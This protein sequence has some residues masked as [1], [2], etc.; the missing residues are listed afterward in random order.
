MSTPLQARVVPFMAFLL[1]GLLQT[2]PGETMRYWGYLAKTVFGAILL[3]R[4]WPLVPEARWKWSWEAVAA[5]VLVLV[6]WVG[7]E[8][9]YPKLGKAGPAWNPFAT[10][11]EGSWAGGA[12]VVMRIL[13]SSLVVPPMEEMFFRSFAYRYIVKVEFA[14]VSLGTLDLPAFLLTSVL[15]AVEHREWLPGLLC[16]F[17]YQAVVLRKGRLGDAMVAHAI[18]NFLLGLWVVWKGAW[19]F[20]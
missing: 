16:G 9:W 17:I 2:L 3:W 7:L 8:G 5:G 11:G 18:T 4:I 1:V 14:S 12:F 13:G 19:Q 10:Y 6:I 15:F 20:W